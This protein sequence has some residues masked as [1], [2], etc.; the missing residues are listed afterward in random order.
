VTETA[1]GKVVFEGEW[2]FGTVRFTSDGSRMLMTETDGRI[3]WVKTATGETEVE[4]AFQPQTFPRMIAGLSADGSLFIYCGKPPGL[5]LDNYLVDGRTGQV[6]RKVGV[7]FSGDRG[8]LSADGRWLVSAS[9]DPTD[10]RRMAAVI[11]DAR[12][13]EVLLRTPLEAGLNDIQRAAFVPDGKS[14]VIHHR[15]QREV[16][17]YELR[18][19]VPEVPAETPVPTPLTPIPERAAA[20]AARPPAPEPVPPGGGIP[21]APALGLRWTVVADAANM[22]NGLPQAPLYSQDGRT[23]VLS[24]GTKGSILT[25]DARTGTPAAVFRGHE[26]PGGVLWLAPFGKDRVA[27]G[28]FDARNA[29]WDTR[30]AKRVDD[31]PFADL[32]PLPDEARGHAG[33]THAV[34]PGGRYTVIARRE[35]LRPVVPGPLRLLDTTTK[36]VVLRLPWNGGR[37]AFTPDESRVFILDGLGRAASYKLPSGELDGEWRTGEGIQAEMARLMGMTADGRVG[38][39]HGPIAG[40][41]IGSYLID[42]RTGHVL[43]KLGG[44][45]YQSAFSALSPDGRHAAMLVIDFNRD[46]TRHVDLFEVN[47]WRLVGR[48]TGPEKSAR[49]TPHFAFSPDSKELA[50]FYPAAKELRVVP[51]PEAGREVAAAPGGPLK[52]RWIGNPASG[53]TIA[54]FLFDADSDTILLSNAH[55]DQ[56]D[57]ID[58]RTGESIPGRLRGLQRRPGG[59]VV[60]LGGGRMGVLNPKEGNLAVVD[61]RTGQARDPIRIPEL[62]DGPQG[63]SLRYACV[64]PDGKYLV[65]GRRGHGISP[66]PLPLRVIERASGKTLL[67]TEW[68]GGTVHFT[69]D[70]RRLLVAEM[71]GQG[72]W[73][74]LPTCQLDGRW[75]LQGAQAGRGHEMTSMSADGRFLGY[76]GPGVGN[77]RAQVAVL[78][79]RTGEVSRAF[80]PEYFYTS[81]VWLSADGRRAAVMRAAPGKGSEMTIDVVRLPGGEILGRAVVE[82]QARSVPMFRLNPDGKALLV[83]DY[84]GQ[85]LYWFDLPELPR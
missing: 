30:T 69:G 45:P 10:L 38:L 74:Q 68:T 33:I 19:A 25:F 85:K 78:D 61:L 81:P 79:A 14:F 36:R 80:G 75:Q 41:G 84:N 40:R 54:S 11:A 63:F 65:V 1:T 6:L 73:F 44:A 2:S 4:W 37:V 46:A 9:N 50:L 29:T 83:H 28:G 5:P 57:V 26:G 13:G 60:P 21:P 59:E 27:S 56:H 82:T 49:E 52:P 39:Y 16:A 15:G 72:R 8:I 7:G 3:R 23:I 47:G 55:L 22:A 58:A 35:S 34:S 71:N 53:H 51:V 42:V 31:I 77:E 32:P 76:T 20:A 24:G 12:T 48:I 17:V 64:S 67:T 66:E 70:S 18:G 43:R 62:P